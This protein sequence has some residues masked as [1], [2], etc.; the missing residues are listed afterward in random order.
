MTVRNDDR[1]W[2]HSCCRTRV[3]ATEK[4]VAETEWIY[5]GSLK[6]GDLID[7]PPHEPHATRKEAEDCFHE[8]RIAQIKESVEF[9][10]VVFTDW[11]GC[12][13]VLGSP[14]FEGDEDSGTR[15]FCD[16]PTKGGARYRDDRSPE[17]LA[18]CT[19]HR[20]VAHVLAQA[21]RYTASTYS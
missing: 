9:E 2:A 10:D 3:P 8:W 18:L 6:V 19:D 13:A 17:V 12:R 21:G 11:Q 4:D 5:H 20:D 14:D 15:S 1:V 16:V 7:G